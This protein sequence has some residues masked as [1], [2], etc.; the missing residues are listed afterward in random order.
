MN[1]QNIGP[2]YLCRKKMIVE[3]INKINPSTILEV[4]CGSGDLAERL[5][6]KY[7]YTGIDI[8]EHNIE[9][10]KKSV[11]NGNFICINLFKFKS[12]KKFDLLICSEVIEHVKN[13]Y[14]FIKRLS[15]YIKKGGFL[16]LSTPGRRNLVGKNDI[17]AGHYRRYEF[18]DLN[19][20]ATKSKLKI[21]NLYSIG[22]PIANLFKFYND[23]RAGNILKNNKLHKKNMFELTKDSGIKKRNR[24]ISFIFN[25]LTMIPFYFLQQLFKRSQ[26]GVDYFLVAQK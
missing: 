20:L 6:S 3:A 13:D 8:N 4:G 15:N 16:L 21:V 10:L 18:E 12:E 1:E 25:D 2:T 9:S 19:K 17:L 14:A 7:D 23:Y 24:F 5:S 11:P 22:I 26:L